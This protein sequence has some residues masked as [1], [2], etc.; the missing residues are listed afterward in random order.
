MSTTTVLKTPYH[1]TRTSFQATR[2]P[3][4][5][6]SQ[7]HG[8]T[9]GF[10]EATSGQDT[11]SGHL[12]MKQG[13][14]RETTDVVT[15]GFKLRQ[16]RGE[17]L[18]NPFRSTTV[19]YLPAFGTMVHKA[20]DPLSPG[21]QRTHSGYLGAGFGWS[22]Q[23]M[24]PD[25][26]PAL[27]KP[28]SS[29]LQREIAA[30]QI[31]A[32]SRVS[33]PEIASLVTLAEAHK[34]V[35][36]IGDTARKLANAYLAVRKGR[37]KAAVEAALG[38]KFKSAPVRNSLDATSNKWLEYRYGWG[39]LMLDVSGTLQAVAKGEF[40]QPP[41]QT[42]RGFRNLTERTTWLDGNFYKPV[43]T[44]HQGAYQFRYEQADTV[45]IRSY[46]LYTVAGNLQR[47]NDF[48]FLAFPSSAWEL[49]PFSFVVDWFTP[50]GDWLQAFDPKVG[51]VQLASG[52]TLRRE[53]TLSRVIHA[54]QSP[55]DTDG[56]K[57]RPIVS[58][59][60]H[61]DVLKVTDLTRVVPLGFP[62]LPPIDVKINV[63][64]AIDSLALLRGVSRS[65]IRV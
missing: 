59:V 30:A 63:K 3:L 52:Y 15:P 13:I 35:Q 48:G 11:T 36:L 40:K 39:P 34:S 14:D 2:L 29:D 43:N 23:L 18:N 56:H 16:A 7:N 37:P 24:P 25:F 42:A 54:Y 51:V 31:A 46:I 26:S 62:A 65:S 44:N 8:H 22:G 32:Y 12:G 53:T 1:R 33:A 55:P 10:S 49:I 57:Y 60:G 4:T 21:C 27:L 45:T 20:T 41:R 9:D 61:A 50:V 28:L 17:I 58:A 38:R 19:E 6:W 64:R 47:I 5:T